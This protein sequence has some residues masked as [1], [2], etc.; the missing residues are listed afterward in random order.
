MPETLP[1]P[2]LMAALTNLLY[3]VV[4]G[5]ATI[6]INRPERRNAL[7]EAT[8][9]ELQ[10]AFDEANHDPAAGVIVLTGA[11]EQA[12]ASGADLKK[13]NT[14]DVDEYR[15]YLSTNAATRVKIF[16]LD[17]PVIAR[18]NGP[19]LGGAMSLVTSCDIVVAVDDAKFG[20]TEINVGLV[21]GI[22]HLWTLG[23]ALTTELMMTGRIFS[24]EEACRLGIVNRVVP[25][26]QLDATVRNYA[27]ELLA[28]SPAA[29]AITKRVIAGALQA[30]GFAMARSLQFE[31]VLEAFATEDRK[32]GMSAFIEKRQARFRKR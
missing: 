13:V 2:G 8:Y 14:L 4:G 10:R 30:N 19:A 24:A 31:A 27:D 12:F 32:E 9:R 5:V 18:V 7:D 6:T 1:E 16:S 17:K 3:S 26:D 15:A 25:R 20:Q 21:G 22:D 11:G 29:L 28:R 23:K